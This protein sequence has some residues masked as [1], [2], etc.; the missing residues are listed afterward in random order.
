MLATQATLFSRNLSGNMLLKTN[1][2]MYNAIPPT[3][4]GEAL[5]YTHRLH[6]TD[7]VNQYCKYSAL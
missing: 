5:H 7:Q 1:V 4:G 2:L 3:D 6:Y